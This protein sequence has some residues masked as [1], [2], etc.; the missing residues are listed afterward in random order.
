MDGSE[1]VRLRCRRG[2]PRKGWPLRLIELKSNYDEI[3]TGR[4]PEP[5]ASDP[6]GRRRR[7]PNF[8]APAR[9]GRVSFRPWIAGFL[10]LPRRGP[11]NEKCCVV[12]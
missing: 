5:S 10:G 7:M 11:I 8:E 1:E 3:R 2:D 9:T 4:I 6:P 12:R